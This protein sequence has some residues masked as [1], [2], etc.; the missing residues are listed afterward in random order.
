MIKQV[1]VTGGAGFIGSHTVDALIDRGYRVTVYDNLESQVHGD[2]RKPPSYLNPAAEFVLGD[3]TD[4]EALAPYLKKADAVFHLAAA[5]GVGQSMYEIGKYVSNNIV[6]SAVLLELLVKEKIPMKKLIIASSMST[7][8]EGLYRCPGCGDIAPRLRDNEQL[9]KSEWEMKCPHCGMDAEKAAT[10]EDKPLFPTSVY[11]VSKRDQEEM[12]LAVGMAYQLP[13]VA[14]RYFNVYG[15]R[16]AL[17]NPYTG[18][19]AIFSSRLLNDNPPVIYEDGNQCRDFTHVTDI[20]QANLLALE[21]H[22]ADFQVFNVGTGKGTSIL[23]LSKLVARGLG[24]EAIRPRILGK[25]R[26]GDIRHCYASIAHI[27]KTLGYNPRVN[28][29]DGIQDLVSWVANQT[30]DDRFRIASSELEHHGLTF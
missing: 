1:L 20:V 23:E 12:F 15:P 11:A 10:R 2:E 6:G 4:R 8:G 26:S 22:E 13:T 14:L 28:L 5:V 27:H 3:V 7:Y 17:N 9:E 29:E 25:F 30:S 19:G 21:M 24:K 18:V 16:Q